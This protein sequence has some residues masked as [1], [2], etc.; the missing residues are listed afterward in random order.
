MTHKHL[1][2][3]LTAFI[4]ALMFFD[5]PILAHDETTTSE[6][7]TDTSTT[8]PVDPS[9]PDWV[10]VDLYRHDATH[11]FANVD[12]A[13]TIIPEILITNNLDVF[14]LPS[15]WQSSTSYEWSCDNCIFDIDSISGEIFLAFE[16]KS[17]SSI[18]SRDSHLDFTRDVDSASSNRSKHPVYLKLKVTVN[19]DDH[20]Y[21]GYS[22][23]KIFFDQHENIPPS[24]PDPTVEP[25]TD[26]HYSDGHTH[27]D[28]DHSHDEILTVMP[29]EYETLCDDAIDNDQDGFSDC[30]DADCFSVCHSPIKDDSTALQSENTDLEVPMAQATADEG[31]WVGCSLQTPEKNSSSGLSGGL[32]TLALMFMAIIRTRNHGT[33]K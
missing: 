1:K 16:K 13:V 4:L 12:E 29:D 22:S 7:H 32:L 24:T 31:L 26:D 8:E 5:K 3:I 15:E 2:F 14:K 10:D 18:I 19:C 17:F 21:F 11:P 6:T 28:L 27:D 25:D 33:S 9:C 20:E 30:Y 23:Y